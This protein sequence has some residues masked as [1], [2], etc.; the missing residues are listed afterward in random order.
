MMLDWVKKKWYLFAAG[1]MGLV[2]L[3]AIV[4]FRGRD[5]PQIALINTLKKSFQDQ[6]KAVEDVQEKERKD[7]AAA[8]DAHQEELR[9]L[10]SQHKK[11][12]EEVKSNAEKSATEMASKDSEE[13]A[14]ALKE[15][16][17]L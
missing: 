9:L 4:V 11:A 2:A 8:L 12:V 3:V 7:K 15:E 6:L 10:D 1:A 16:F 13:I 17:R 5:K 14:T